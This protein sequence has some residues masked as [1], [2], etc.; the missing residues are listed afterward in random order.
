M[1]NRIMINE[2]EFKELLSDNM[3]Y[4]SNFQIDHFITTKAGGTHYGMYCQSLR[5]LDG[6]F[7]ALKEMI[8]DIKIEKAE[9]GDLEQKAVTMQYGFQKEI[10]KLKALKKRMAIEGMD[11]ALYH[12]MREFV[13]FYYQAK[14]LKA[15]IGDLGPTKRARLEHEMWLY[16]LRF[17]AYIDIVTTGRVSNGVFENILSLKESDRVELI[18]NIETPS[19]L[20]EY[21]D[22][23]KIELPEYTVQ[24]EEIESIR[25]LIDVK[26]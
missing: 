26:P 12:K 23:R 9:A 20:V 8:I 24:T 1:A 13:R 18:S 11:R 22:K 7:A 6:R 4:H 5:E 19:V 14:A 17:H 15:E 25:S 3:I 10:L 21:F 16:K 2:K